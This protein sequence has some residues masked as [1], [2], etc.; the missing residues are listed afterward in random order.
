MTEGKSG[1]KIWTKLKN[2][3]FLQ[4]MNVIRAVKINFASAFSTKLENTT[5][6]KIFQQ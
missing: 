5:A 2:Q 6:H 3:Y 1:K 4:K